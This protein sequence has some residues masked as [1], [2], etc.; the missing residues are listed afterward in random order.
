MK[1]KAAL[2]AMIAW[3]CLNS[4]VWASEATKGVPKATQPPAVSE[5]Q[6]Q[7]AAMTMEDLPAVVDRFRTAHPEVRFYE[8]GSQIT[9]VYGPAFG[10]GA[11]AV[12][13]AEQFR[14]TYA[15][16]FG[17][18]PEDLEP[19]SW[20]TDGRHTQ[21]LMYDRRT[22]DYEFTL[23]YYSQFKDGY[24]VFR[25]QLKLL[26]RNEAGYPLVLAAAT[27]RD[28]GPF[29]PVVTEINPEAGIQAA[30]DRIP[31]LVNFT[32]PELVI[33]A[34]V[35]DMDVEPALAMTFI[36]DN[37]GDPAVERLERWLYVT[38]AAS[39]RIL[40]EEDQIVFEDVEGSVRGNAT[41]GIAADFCGMTMSL[42]M[43]HARVNIGSTIAFA[44]VNGLFVIPNPGTTPVTVES[45]MWGEWFKVE[46]AA[47]ANALMTRSVTPPGPA[48][49]IHNSFNGEFTRAEVNG[50]L[51]A[52]VIRD[53]ILV[54]NPSYPGLQ[55]NDYTVNVNKTGGI[56][57]GNAQYT[58]S[59]INFCA[60]GNGYPNT[61][62]SSVIYHEYG[63]HLVAMAGSGQ[64][65]YGEGMGDVVSNLI[66]DDPGTGYGFFGAGTCNTPLR[67]ADN[68][69]QYLTSGCSTCGSEIHDCGRLLSGCVWSTRNEL[70][71]TNPTT[72]RDIIS[73][74]AINSML[75][76]S[77]SSINPSITIDYLT[78]DDDD[79]NIFNGTPHYPEI[80]AGFS[81]HS[82]PAP[83]LSSIAFEY[84]SGL[85]ELIMPDQPTIVQVN[86][87]PVIGT[88]VAGT[89]TVSHR[90]GGGAFTTEAMNEISPNQYE[91]TLPG[92]PCIEVVDFY[93]SAE[94]DG[95]EI[96][97]D[98]MD[99]P[100]SFYSTVAASDIITVVAYDF[101]TNPGWTV[102]GSATEGQWE[103]GIPVACN[104]GDPP[105][106]ND[107][108]GQ[109]WLT[110]NNAGDCN[111]D[112]DDGDTVLTSNRID[113]GGWTNPYVRYARWYSNDWGSNPQEDVFTVEVSDN[114]GAGWTQLEVVGPTGPEVQ[115]G[116]YVKSFRLADVISITSQFRIRFKAF[117]SPNSG[118]VVEAAV[119]AF[120]IFEYLCESPCPGATGDMNGDTFVNGL[121]VGSFVDAI[122]GTP[123]P[124]E[125]CAGDFDES[126][127]LGTGDIPG[128]AAALLAG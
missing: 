1:L 82:M 17:V 27:L 117:D 126:G 52:N 77:G 64:G 72:Y 35:E 33:W 32:E 16:V 12:D 59:A 109:C 81:A 105:T 112:V 93:F 46:N 44:D 47:G 108:S 5:A 55:Q 75:L 57:P 70:L 19:V 107:G 83:E 6:G 96:I 13:T 95:G 128:F 63:H 80:N 100:A 65:A 103:R 25:A 121:D 92:A 91:A 11:S 42:S 74:L 38:D 104:R 61:A 23:V 43:P 118:S 51:H 110:E 20:L 48:N 88:P 21:P 28:L 115:G 71:V 122:L 7:R 34:G 30:I 111:S 26:V 3:A 101:E 14:S 76:H 114:D 49:F 97:S 94:D 50:Y 86:V 102:S 41:I 124:E 85:P 37:D 10:Q 79:G 9:R 29:S 40:Y 36:A 120:E 31:S 73:D 69:C 54:Y 127:D 24:P 125:I 98:P 119:D 2:V 60:A 39:G 58:G 45:R 84:P 4:A 90:V 56:C 66:Q 53:Y 67:N 15:E 89:G 62:W 106:D 8:R 113:L 22:E 68:N 116:W 78:L 99:A 87:V 18:H 123:T